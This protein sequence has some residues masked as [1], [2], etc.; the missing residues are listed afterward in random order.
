MARCKSCRQHFHTTMASRKRRSGCEVPHMPLPI[1]LTFHSPTGPQWCLPC[2]T[3]KAGWR[4]RQIE[5]ELFDEP[6]NI[7]WE[8]SPLEFCFFNISFLLELCWV[9]RCI[10]KQKQKQ[11]CGTM[12]LL[13]SIF[14]PPYSHLVAVV[15]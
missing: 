12:T 3:K 5:G 14:L 7:P 10:Q 6:P 2:G 11:S 15:V 9:I 13:Y 8:K 4:Q 1:V